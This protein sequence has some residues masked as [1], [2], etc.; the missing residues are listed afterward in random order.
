MKKLSI[1]LTALFAM[2]GW[3]AAYAATATGNFNV[4]INLTTA[5]TVNSASLA[6]AFT[7]ADGTTPTV[8]TSGTMTYTVACTSGVPYTMALDAASV[9]TPPAAGSFTYVS[10][11]GTTYTY[12][13]GVTNLT[14]SL[15]LPAAVAGAGYGSPHTYTM[16]DAMSNTGQT[17]TCASTGGCTGTN[18]HTITVTF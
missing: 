18:A 3:S 17:P 10:T 13:D 15:T 16:T 8:T 14:Y 4:T 7:Y 5:C 11:A 9:G 12:T 2:W 1:L 6:P